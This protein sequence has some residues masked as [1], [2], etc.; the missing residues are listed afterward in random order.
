MKTKDIAM[1]LLGGLICIGFFVLLGILLSKNIPSDNRDVLNL[2]IGAL[3]GSFTTVVT[4]FYG[5]SQGS[6]DKNEMLNKR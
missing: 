5:S 4:Y 2:V 1:Y 3:I 6:K